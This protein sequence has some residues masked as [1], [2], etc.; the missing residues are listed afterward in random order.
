MLPFYLEFRTEA[1]I[2]AEPPEL[3]SYRPSGADAAINGTLTLTFNEPMSPAGDIIINP[4]DGMSIQ[5]GYW[6]ADG[7]R[8]TAQYSGLNYGTAYFIHLNGFA[9]VSGNLL[10]PYQPPEFTTVRTF[11]EPAAAPQRLDLYE[12]ETGQFTVFL[13][14]YGPEAAASAELSGY[15]GSV[16]S[17]DKTFISSETDGIMSVTGL[18]H[19]ETDILITFTGPDG[20]TLVQTAVHAAVSAAPRYLR[21]VLPV[22]SLPD[23]PYGTP[24]TD[25]A[26]GLPQTVTLL[27]TDGTR[28]QTP[29]IWDTDSAFYDPDDPDMR[30]FTL[31]GEVTLPPNIIPQGTVTVEV[32]VSV[33]G[34]YTV[35]FD[36]NGGYP[37]TQRLII[38]AGESAGG[39]MPVA[40]RSG[41]NFVGWNTSPGGNGKPFTGGTVVT[42]DITVYALWQYAGYTK[43]PPTPDYPYYPYYPEPTPSPAP[44][45]VYTPAPAPVQTPAPTPTP[46][47]KKT[48]PVNGGANSVTY[49]EDGEGAVSLEITAQEI[50]EIIKKAGEEPVDFDLSGLSE[51]TEVNIPASA[52]RMINGSRLLLMIKTPLGDITLGPAAMTGAALNAGNGYI[53]LSFTGTQGL[54]ELALYG[55]TEYIAEFG[56]AV[57]ISVPYPLS[58]GGNPGKLYAYRTDDNGLRRTVY[59]EYDELAGALHFIASGSSV[60]GVGLADAG[61]R[62]INGHWAE[63]AISRSGASGLAAGF[64]DGYFGPDR[65]ITRAEF[66]QFIYAVAGFSPVNGG[67][68]FTDVSESDWYCTAVSALK[69][70]HVLQGL[71]RPDGSLGPDEPITRAEA[72]VMLGNL[73]QVKRIAPVSAVSAQTFV[74]F[75]EIGIYAESVEQSIN[76]GFLNADGVGGG[77]FAPF[78]YLTRAQA[79]VIQI[80][81][82][83]ALSRLR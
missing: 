30:I 44:A 29:V 38:P 49:T 31:Y 67:L 82:L 43:T 62:D 68:P 76:A 13:G 28:E 27:F 11:D 8:Y 81:V 23:I 64:G 48:I 18:A 17:L 47:P 66:A 77:R 74:D 60:Y 2:D 41:Y 72:A 69:D 33:N 35:T 70:A 19:G 37:Q 63:N 54:Y 61:F 46:V 53:R 25:I 78:D 4:S 73:A 79:A 58:A 22:P 75:N 80:T 1:Y 10:E 42:G 45:P 16:I 52:L 71:G 59:S 40:E 24:M 21:R 9:D 51:L 55:G 56:G 3:V 57:Q 20:L 36:G 7:L 12:G 32:Y 83:K 39:A 6:S 65:Q 50:I 14:G 26:A 34:G 15:D 5:P